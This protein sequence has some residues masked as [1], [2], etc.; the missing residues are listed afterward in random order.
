M[1]IADGAPRAYNI[2]IGGFKIYRKKNIIVTLRRAGDQACIAFDREAFLGSVFVHDQ[3]V[4]NEVV[5]KYFNARQPLE[6]PL[7]SNV[8]GFISEHCV[9]VLLSLLFFVVAGGLSSSS[10]IQITEQCMMPPNAD[11]EELG[12]PLPRKAQRSHAHSSR[13]KRIE[14]IV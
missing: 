7:C 13:L 11:K 8:V 6:I 5:R 12:F 10:T 14:C 9:V 3:H 4:G 2:A 1:M